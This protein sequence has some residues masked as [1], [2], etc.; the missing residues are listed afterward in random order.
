MKD[1]PTVAALVARGAAT[2][3][4]VA[5]QGPGKPPVRYGDLLRGVTATVSR[6]N[7]LGIRRND[8]VAVVLPNGAEMAVSFLAVASGATCAP[9]NPGFRAAEFDFYLADLDAK[10]LIVKRGEETPAREV[11]RARKVPIVE[12]VPSADGSGLFTL[13]ADQGASESACTWAQ[14]DDVALILHTSGTTSRPKM[15]PLTHTN[16]F[17]SANHIRE[18]LSLTPQDRCLNVM[19]LFHIHGIM[20]ALLASIAAGGSVVTSPR[21]TAPTFFEWLAETR[22]TW[23]TAVPTIHQAVLELAPSHRD[24]LQRQPLRFIRSSSAALPTRVMAELEAIFKAPVI[25]AYG[26]TEASHQ[27]ASNP[28]PPQARKPGSVGRPAGPEIAI[29][30]GRGDPQPPGTKGEISIRGPNVTRGY[31]NNPTANQSA[32]TNGFFRTGD[33]GYFDPDGYLFLTGRIKEMIN[34]AGEKIAPLEV[35]E[36]LM[37]HPAVAAAV[38]FAVPHPALGEDVA[39]AVVLKPGSAVAPNELRD[40]V[41]QR[42]VDYKV[43]QQV[44][45]LDEIP[46][47]PT[48]KM[49]RIGLAEKLAHRLRGDF[50]APRNQVEVDLAEIWKDVL[51]VDRVGVRDNFFSLGGDS[52]KAT[53]VIG[54]ARLKNIHVDLIFQRPTIAEL[55][56][57]QP[58]TATPSAPGPV[59]TAPV[60]APVATAV[61]AAATAEPRDAAGA[62]EGVKPRDLVFVALLILTVVLLV[63]RELWHR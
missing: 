62:E 29:L 39:A 18:T 58:N 28:L 30:D 31:E 20:G 59:G 63:A 13:E 55:A 22:A 60:A 25:E 15:V 35:D 41:A 32:F 50:V 16:V 9:L 4:A 12:L 1:E 17:R 21:F 42:L 36:V 54:R 43:P 38:T 46:K 51:R 45:I 19:P 56:E 2:P 48:G 7:G 8:R 11:A 37:A 53:A 34:R 14:P 10:A 3:D 33:E 27:M 57:A 23:Y 61:A 52:L 47:G 24:L 5:I 40:F 26:M 6:L 49:Q 44:L